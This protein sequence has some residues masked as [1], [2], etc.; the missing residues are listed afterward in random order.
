[1]GLYVT[2][3][4]RTE[5]VELIKALGADKVFDSVGKSTFSQCKPLLKKDGTY[6]SSELGPYAQNPFLALATPLIAGK[7]VKF[8]VPVNVR[9]SLDF[10]K[11]LI[12]EG[13]FKPL[14]DKCYSLEQVREAYRYVLSGQKVGNVI[15]L[16]NDRSSA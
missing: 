8:P 16:I 14:I 9:R 15:L 1:M 2:A 5:H 13:R 10:V 4:C 11:H 12:E 6:I 3:V 7:Q